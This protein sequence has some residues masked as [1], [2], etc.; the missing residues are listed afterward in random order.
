MAEQKENFR[1]NLSEDEL[2]H[3]KFK[4]LKEMKNSEQELDRLKESAGAAD[5]DVDDQKSEQDHHF[6]DRAT[7]A[8]IKKTS[9]S[10]IEQQKEKIEKIKVALDRISSGTYGICTVT[11]KPIQKERLEAIPYTMHSV[12]AKK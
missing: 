9:L 12:D 7:D 11:G 3:F 4:L 5:R 2:E 8:E 10:L 1:T 6:G